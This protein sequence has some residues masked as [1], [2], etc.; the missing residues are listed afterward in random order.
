MNSDVIKFRD[1]VLAHTVAYPLAMLLGFIA[2]HLFGFIG[3]LLPEIYASGPGYVLW[4]AI[5]GGIIGWVQWHFLRKKTTITSGWIWRSAIGFGIAEIL[6]VFILAH[7]GIDR[8]IDIAFSYGMEVWTLIYLVGGA[9]TGY[10]Q[11]SYLKK[12]TPYFRFWTLA[13]SIIWGL[14]TLVWTGIIR[15]FVINPIVT[16][17]GGVILGALSAFVLN[18][19]FKYSHS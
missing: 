3:N 8:N 5:I 6:G 9:I 2:I 11:S 14:S 13:N 4:A 19:F 15:Y 18:K 17:L 1:W 16:L 10:L 12:I 7:Y